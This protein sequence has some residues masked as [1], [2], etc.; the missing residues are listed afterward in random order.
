MDQ[1]SMANMFAAIREEHGQTDDPSPNYLSFIPN[2]L[3]SNVLLMTSQSLRRDHMSTLFLGTIRPNYRE[4]MWTSDV[5]K[6]Q[7]QLGP[8]TFFEV[9]MIPIY[10]APFR[11]L[12]TGDAVK[13]VEI[14]LGHMNNLE[15]SS[16]IRIICLG[17]GHSSLLFRAITYL[18]KE[19]RNRD[20]TL[21][22]TKHLQLYTSG[23]TAKSDMFCFCKWLCISGTCETIEF[24]D[25]QDYRP[26]GYCQP[27]YE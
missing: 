25:T 16:R 10:R 15:D 2:Q 14:A 24:Y 4:E 1:G 21:R 13:K 19:W 12:D 23:D 5:Q 18:L 11:E 9:K 17:T 7:E 27:Q 8:Q 26:F 22:S 6:W 20:G 3:R